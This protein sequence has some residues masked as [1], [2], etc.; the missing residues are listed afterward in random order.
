M[1]GE[2]GSYS[3]TNQAPRYYINQQEGVQT[4]IK[5]SRYTKKYK[6]K[7]TTATD[8]RT[9]LND[10]EAE[11]MEG[12]VEVI[13]EC[14]ELSGG[15]GFTA[16]C[17]QEEGVSKKIAQGELRPASNEELLRYAVNNI[18]EITTEQ[19]SNEAF[20]GIL[21]RLMN[22]N[23]SVEVVNGEIN[24]RNFVELPAVQPNTSAEQQ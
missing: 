12:S 2:T 18:N 4:L 8:Y 11:T 3:R 21:D 14:S 9:A 19:D 16:T 24:D 15:D 13:F 23:E 10:P 1:A 17:V 7:K 6:I 22:V 5:E 20:F